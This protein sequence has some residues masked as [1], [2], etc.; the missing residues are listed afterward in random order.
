MLRN[1]LLSLSHSL[2]SQIFTV[3]SNHHSHKTIKE[4]QYMCTCLLYTSLQILSSSSLTDTINIISVDPA[5]ITPTH[6]MNSSI[7]VLIAE[8]FFISS[9]MPWHNLFFWYIRTT[10]D[11]VL[12]PNCLI[13]PC[14]GYLKGIAGQY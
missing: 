1:P 3:E 7:D 2:S 4:V 5:D 10:L 11:T 12:S 9:T 14:T 13:S 6:L 8:P